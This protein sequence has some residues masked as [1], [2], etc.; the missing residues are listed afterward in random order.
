MFLQKP[1]KERL[2]VYSATKVDSPGS[3]GS[4]GSRGTTRTFISHPKKVTM[5][6]YFRREGKFLRTEAAEAIAK[7]LELPVKTV[8]LYFKNRRAQEKKL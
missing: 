4:G 6:E 2:S 7:E 8:K 1:L 5:N 3:S